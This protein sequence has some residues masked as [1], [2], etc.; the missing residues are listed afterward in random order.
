MTA[1]GVDMTIHYDDPFNEPE[2]KSVGGIAVVDDEAFEE[3]RENVFNRLVEAILE[4][5]EDGYAW[6][7][8]SFYDPM[9]DGTLLAY[10]QSKPPNL[11]TPRKGSRSVH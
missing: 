1:I 10:H 2:T 9:D 5:A 8:C 7:T 3:D 4:E 6:W 11:S